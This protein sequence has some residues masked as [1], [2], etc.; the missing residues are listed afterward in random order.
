MTVLKDASAMPCMAP[1]VPMC[2]NDYHKTRSDAQS[3]R[4]VQSQLAGN[5]VFKKV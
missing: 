3:K 2:G 4:I 1:V 5:P